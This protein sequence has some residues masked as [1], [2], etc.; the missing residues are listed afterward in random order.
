MAD[1]VRAQ[2]ARYRAGQDPDWSEPIGVE[3]LGEVETR[4]EARETIRAYWKTHKIPARGPSIEPEI[5]GGEDDY[6]W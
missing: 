5:F 3:E 2:L 1:K 4:E 6:D